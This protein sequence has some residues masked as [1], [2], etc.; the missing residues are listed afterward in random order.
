MYTPIGFLTV[1]SSVR[2]G[3]KVM[4]VFAINRDETA[5]VG[6]E[7]I[8]IFDTQVLDLEDVHAVQNCAP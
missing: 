5:V 1:G 6:P 3:G 8:V 7:G 2:K 4:Q